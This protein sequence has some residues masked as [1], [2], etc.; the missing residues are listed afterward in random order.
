[1]SPA[2]LLPTS[3]RAPPTRTAGA[4]TNPVRATDCADAVLDVMPGV[5]DAM[6]GAM[7]RQVGEQLSVPQFRCLQHIALRPGCSVSDV[8]KFLG[9]TLPTASA[10]IDRLVKAGSVAPAAAAQDRR[11]TELRLT[12]SGQA[13]LKQIRQGARQ[14]FAQ[15][16]DGCTDSELRTVR[17]GLAV[18]Q[19]IF[20]TA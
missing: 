15:A 6:R 9:V 19:R 14:D 12:A 5:M 16:L 1:M 17:A 18:L 7:R 13:Q 2:S 20:H 8:A 11:R 10:M 4:E 3:R